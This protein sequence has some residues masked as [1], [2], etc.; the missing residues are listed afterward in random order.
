MPFLGPTV[1][2]CIEQQGMMCRVLLVRLRASTTNGGVTHKVEADVA[3]G[4]DNCIDCLPHKEEQNP[5]EQQVHMV[6]EN[7]NSFPGAGTGT[8]CGSTEETA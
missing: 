8:H 5:Q 1:T 2:P 6:L 4:A 3:A 7:M